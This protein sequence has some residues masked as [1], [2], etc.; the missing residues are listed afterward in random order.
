MVATPV[1]AIP[2]VIEDGVSGLLVPAG[3]PAALAEALIRVVAQPDLR[4][5]L[6]DGARR[7]FNEKFEI[8]VYCAQLEALYAQVSQR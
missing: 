4:A 6:A 2:E 3:D 1:G 8:S 5:A 7:C